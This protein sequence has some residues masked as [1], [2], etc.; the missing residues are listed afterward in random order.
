LTES[1]EVDLGVVDAELGRFAH[2]LF[3]VVAGAGD[4]AAAAVDPTVG[5]ECANGA[6]LLLVLP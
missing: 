6:A 5:A 1:V 4:T 3:L 2:G